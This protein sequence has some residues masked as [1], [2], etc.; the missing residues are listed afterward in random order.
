MPPDIEM[1][2]FADRICCSTVLQDYSERERERKLRREGG[3]SI[4]KYVGLYLED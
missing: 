3:E 1:K 4:F 2:D